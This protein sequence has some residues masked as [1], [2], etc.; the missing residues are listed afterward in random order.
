M[1]VQKN[2]TDAKL[3]VNSFS[4][5]HYLSF[6]IIYD[7]TTFPQNVEQKCLKINKIENIARTFLYT[8]NGSENVL[9]IL[10]DF[11]ENIRFLK[12]ASR[13]ISLYFSRTLKLV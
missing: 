1:H 11:S 10:R 8:L 5:K 6:Q 9:R 2:M 12:K 3:Y 4:E 7:N 13:T